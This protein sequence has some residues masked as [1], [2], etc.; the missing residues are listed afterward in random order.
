MTYIKGSDRKQITMLTDCIDDLI[1][2]DNP[3]RVI[4]TFI[5]SHDMEEAPKQIHRLLEVQNRELRA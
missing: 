3:V 5:D 2:Q 4:D 1:G